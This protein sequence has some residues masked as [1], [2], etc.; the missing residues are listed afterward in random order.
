MVY[1]RSVDSSTIRADILGI[2]AGNYSVMIAPKSSDT[3]PT[4]CDIAVIAYDRSGYAHFNYTSG[5]GAYNDD[6]TLKDNA[7][8]FICY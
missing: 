1:Q 5:V 6:G 2:S 8:V 3:N 7:I 4:I